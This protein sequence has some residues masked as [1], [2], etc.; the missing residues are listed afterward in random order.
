MHML[1]TWS[2][3]LVLLEEGKF[4]PFGR[5][6]L[7]PDR[8]PSLQVRSQGLTKLGLVVRLALRADIDD[9]VGVALHQ[10]IK[11]LA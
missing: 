10:S 2:K 9:R 3:E 11:M 5:V 7:T 6:L 1:H 8:D 4:V